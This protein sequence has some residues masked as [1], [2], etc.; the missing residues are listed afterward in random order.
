MQLMAMKMNMK[1]RT[2]MNMQ[3]TRKRSM[4]LLLVTVVLMIMLTVVPR[5]KLRKL[6]DTIN[7]LNM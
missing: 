4:T 3:P 5:N 1:R 6:I 7:K 2:V